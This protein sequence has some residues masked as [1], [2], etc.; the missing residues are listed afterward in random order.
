VTDAVVK[1]GDVKSKYDQL[2]A[3]V[4]IGEER[5]PKETG[6]CSPNASGGEGQG[7]VSASGGAEMTAWKGGDG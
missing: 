2:A 6:R 3:G 1:G 5:G 4:K 7:D